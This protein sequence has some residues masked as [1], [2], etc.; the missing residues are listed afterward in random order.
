MSGE[1]YAIQF[2]GKECVSTSRNIGLASW[3]GELC[4]SGAC[5]LLHVSF[6]LSIRDPTMIITVK[7]SKENIVLSQ[8]TIKA[9]Q[10]RS[11]LVFWA[12]Y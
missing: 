12:L 7:S 9:M 1:D 6:L 8:D 2:T 11:F 5:F 3:A 10:I 4:R